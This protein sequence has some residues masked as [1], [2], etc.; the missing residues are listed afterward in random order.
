MYGLNYC[1]SSPASNLLLQAV[2]VLSKSKIKAV[3]HLRDFHR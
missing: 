3:K 2:L 1:S